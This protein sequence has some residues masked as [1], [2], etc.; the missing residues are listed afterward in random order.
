[1]AKA[2]TVSDALMLQLIELGITNDKQ[3]RSHARAAT[4]TQQKEIK[5]KAKIARRIF[6]SAANL[7]RFETLARAYQERKGGAAQT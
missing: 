4:K 2:P 7:K 3:L 1:M 6:R 5:G